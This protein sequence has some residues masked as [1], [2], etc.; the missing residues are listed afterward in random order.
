M[1]LLWHS[2]ELGFIYL[3]VLIFIYSFVLP[4]IIQYTVHYTLKEH[5]SGGLYQLQ[6]QIW[7]VGM[8]QNGVIFLL[9]FS[10]NTRVSGTEPSCYRRTICINFVQIQ[11]GDLAHC[12]FGL[13]VPNTIVH[14]R[15]TSSSCGRG[16]RARLDDR[17]CSTDMLDIH[18]DYE[19]TSTVCQVRIESEQSLY[20]QP[21]LTQGFR[22]WNSVIEK[23]T[24]KNVAPF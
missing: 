15:Q 1:F 21:P 19:P 17:A 20:S 6:P 9:F 4:H 23:K 11:F 16:L 14:A 22:S 3:H 10:Y 5:E 12:L 2:Y 8:A 13:V 7:F 18:Q 24:S